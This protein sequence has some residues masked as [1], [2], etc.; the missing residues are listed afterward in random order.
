MH[1]NKAGY[2]VH[3]K[4]Y[5]HR[6]IAEKALGKSL[7]ENCIV[8][9]IDGNKSNNSPSN[10][11][12]CQDESYHRL[13]HARQRVLDLGG[14][15]DTH[16]YCSYHDCLHETSRFS[17]RAGTWNGLHNMCKNATNKYRKT[18]GLNRDKFDWRA[19]LNQQYRRV[20]TNYTTRTVS[21]I[22]PEEESR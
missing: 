3:K 17:T 13:L 20:R 12:I 19:R 21:W 7:P 5:Q 1:K 6:L 15:P 10:L 2:I 9:H 18:K 11:V 22:N 14:Y 4:S 8:H 16:S